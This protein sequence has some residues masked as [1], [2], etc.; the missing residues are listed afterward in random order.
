MDA[1]HDSTMERFKLMPW[2]ID[3]DLR[4]HVDRT[5]QSKGRVLTAEE[6]EDLRG[7]LAVRGVM[8]P[9]EYED[10]PQP[11]PRG[12]RGGGGRKQKRGMQVPRSK[13]CMTSLANPDLEHV[14]QPADGMAGPVFAEDA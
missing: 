4:A 12:L 5:V 7:M 11:G 6:V 1:L 3:E 2:G 13:R 10:E 8:P 9:P 14:E